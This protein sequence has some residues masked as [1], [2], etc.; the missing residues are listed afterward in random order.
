LH[1]PPSSSFSLILSHTHR[2]NTLLPYTTL[3]R[4]KIQV[5]SV[6]S[7]KPEDR[8]IVKPGEKIPVDGT[9]LSGQ[10]AIDE[11]MLTGESIPVE[12]FQ[13]RKSTRL[14]SSHV[15]SSNAVFCLNQER[16]INLV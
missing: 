8:I 6:E 14:N 13:D 7:L 9:I 12:K 1:S 15:S 4:S 11:S 10:L 5:V 2:N 16:L 3:F